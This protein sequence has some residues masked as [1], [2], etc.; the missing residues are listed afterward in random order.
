LINKLTLADVGDVLNP[1][2]VQQILGIGR[3]PTYELIAS[4]R[5]PSVRVTERRI[6]VTK[7]ALEAFLGIASNSADAGTPKG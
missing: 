7:A 2:Q 6:I 4:G 1:H 3:N 5:L